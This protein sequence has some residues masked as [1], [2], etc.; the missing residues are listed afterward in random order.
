[1]I[2]TAANGASIADIEDYCKTLPQEYTW[3]DFTISPTDRVKIHTML[4]EMIDGLAAG[5]SQ[6]KLFQSLQQKHHYSIKPSAFTKVYQEECAAGNLVQNDALEEVLVTSRCRGISGVTVVT[7]FLSPTPNGQTFSCKWNCAYCPNEPGQPRSYLFGEPGVLRAN[8]NGFDCLKQMLARIHTYRVNGHPTDKFEVLILG[9]TI[10]S[11]PK[12]YLETFMRDIFYG[13]NVCLDA[14]PLRPAESL[15]A[16]KLRNRR[17]KHRVI[18]ITVETRPDCITPAELCDFRRWGITRVQVGIQHTDDAI[19]RKVN[20]GCLHKHTVAALKLLKDNCFKV[21]IHIMPNLPGATPDADKAMMDV[22][23]QD[24]HPDQVKVYPCETTP[25]TQILE[26]Y[27]RG[28]YVPY[29]DAMLEEVILYWK[30]RVHPWIRNNRIVR[31]IPNTYI[32][33]GV[34]TS[35]ARNDY[36]ALM[37]ERGLTCRCIR[38]REAGRHPAADPA[39][40]ILMT[41]SYSAQGALEHFISWES[42]DMTVLFGF[43]RLRLPTSVSIF[44]EL[45]GAALIRELHVYGRTTAVGTGSG[46][47][48]HRGIGR[49]LLL[50]AERQARCAGYD[51]IAVISGVGVQ[52]YYENAGYVL[53]AGTGEFLI[54]PLLRWSWSRTAAL[55]AAAVLV[56]AIAI[57][58]YY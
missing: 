36:Q 58:M 13:A 16:E 40:G 53:H 52:E 30:T 2:T 3:R 46:T 12:T 34:P 35:S 37:K 29:S 45:A 44:P 6:K 50:E 54:K 17:G 7:V 55:A 47:V 8:Q 25:F 5:I 48:Q 9:G 15:D 24:L 57:Y 42:A 56:A 27:K 4:I 14:A 10:H 28:T 22:V 51:R 41:R 43:L 33:A 18:G 49:T 20:R 11:Y 26:D 23:L 31:D 32:V 21:D 19:L 1:M 38:C 39:A